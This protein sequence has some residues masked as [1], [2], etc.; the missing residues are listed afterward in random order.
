MD[1]EGENIDD[2]FS[3]AGK[4]LGTDNA[5]TNNVRIIDE[6]FWNQHSNGLGQIDQEIGK[7]NSSILSESK[8]SESAL[9]SIYRFYWKKINSNYSNVNICTEKR[10][11]K[12]GV[13]YMEAKTNCRTYINSVTKYTRTIYVDMDIMNRKKY[14]DNAYDIISCFEHEDRHLFQQSNANQVFLGEEEYDALKTQV[15]SST[16]EKCSPNYQKEIRNQ[17]KEKTPLYI[18]RICPDLY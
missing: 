1:P 8:I 3:K 5:E 12:I 7:S 10:P 18:K 17:L 2:Y 14:S 13:H 9:L 6:V 4:Y 15:N 16:F 11:G